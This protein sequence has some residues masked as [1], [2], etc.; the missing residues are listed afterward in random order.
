MPSAPREAFGDLATTAFV[1]TSILF[2]ALDPAARHDLL[3]LGR[4]VTYAE[5]EV[6]SAEED[7][8]FLI[9]RDGAA[10][11]VATTPAGPLELYR[12]ERGAFFGVGRALGTRRA[13][14]SL[15]AA[16]EVTVVAFPAPVVG[17]LAERSPKIKKLLQAV[18]AAREKEAAARLGG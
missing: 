6:I 13:G 17:A 15:R 4:V 7:D 16:S 12:L 9:V 1:E 2:K 3:R 8:G 14:R 18:Q 11:V 10:A 5:G